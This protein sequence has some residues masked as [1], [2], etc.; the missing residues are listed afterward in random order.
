[1]V[2]H[3]VRVHVSGGGRGGARGPPLC[4]DI[5]ARVPLLRQGLSHW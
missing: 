1:M 5:P 4:L 3:S 2:P